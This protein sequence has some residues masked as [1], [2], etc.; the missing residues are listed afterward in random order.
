MKYNEK[1]TSLIEK[2]NQLDLTLKGVWSIADLS[3][4]IGGGSPLNNMRMIKRLTQSQLIQ[5]MQRGW[6][7]S[8]NANLLILASRINPKSY[9]SME[10]VLSQNILIGSAPQ[11]IISM[12]SLG[13][14]RKIKTSLGLIQYFSSSK[15]LWFGFSKHPE[16]YLIA[17][18][19]KAFLDM[20]YFYNHGVRYVVDPTSEIASEEL[21]QKKIR[22]YLLKY[23]NPKFR[24]FVMNLLEKNHE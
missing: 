2:F 12:M 4:L 19:E 5:K 6:Y 24:K 20:L 10:Y 21:N 18:P 7:V 14:S 22:S 16:G 11:K 9:V 3:N 8:K 13:R 23:Q 15:N 1:T 17:D